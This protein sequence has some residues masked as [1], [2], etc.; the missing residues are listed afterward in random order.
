[1][2]STE[3]EVNIYIMMN[4]VIMKINLFFGKNKTN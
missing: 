2:V 4:I 3:A 1:M